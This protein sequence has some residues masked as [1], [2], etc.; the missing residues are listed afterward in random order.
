MIVV[1]DIGTSRLKVSAF[2]SSGDLL[3]QVARRHLHHAEGEYAW[4]ETGEWWRNACAGF[5]ELMTTADLQPGAVRGFS[6]SGRAGAG[7]FVDG[8]GD[9]L[10]EPWSDGRHRSIL[11]KLRGT[12]PTAP[13]YGLTLIAK[14]AWLQEHAPTRADAVRHCLY[15]KDFLLFKLTGVSQTDPS[16]GPDALDWFDQEV[17]DTDLLPKPQLPWSIAGS[18]TPAAAAELGCEVGIPVALGAHD[19]ICAN[20]GCAMLGEGEYAL[21]LGTHAVC[22]TVT[23]RDLGREERFY[24]YPPALHCYGGN[25]WHIG[26]TLNWMLSIVA[27]LNS[28]LSASELSEFNEGWS[29]AAADPNLIFLPYLGGQTIPEK[30]DAGTGAFLGLSQHTSREQMIH[31]VFQGCAFAVLRTYREIAAITGPASKICLTGGGIVFRPWLQMLA[32]L[33]EQ[34]ISF[35]D[36]GVEGRGAAIFCAVALGDYRD[37]PEAAQAMQSK[38]T[39]ILPRP[40][41]D[42]SRQSFERFEWLSA[43]T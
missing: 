27:G 40:L 11:A 33:L 3:G 28:E 41:D 14:Y 16:S 42:A 36:I 22:R 29:R 4:Q 1:F 31:A 37:I 38:A 17:V 35:T 39:S 32:D 7:V 6:V 15:A 34:E 43:Q 18:T 30:R 9:V 13:T 8:K 20:T 12:Y 23:A 21:T 10:A 2:S 24:C 26:T 5:A 25:S 19:G